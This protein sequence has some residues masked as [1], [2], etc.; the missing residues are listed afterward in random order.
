MSLEASPGAWRAYKG[1]RG[2]PSDI[3]VCQAG[4]E[5]KKQAKGQESDKGPMGQNKRSIGQEEGKANGQKGQPMV[6]EV[7]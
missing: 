1:Q 4:K 3:E 2:R 7:D 5:G 6:V